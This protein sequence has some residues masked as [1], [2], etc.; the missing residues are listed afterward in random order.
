M[1]YRCANPAFLYK[2]SHIIVINKKLLNFEQT[3][4]EDRNKGRSERISD[5]STRVAKNTLMLYF[6]MLL[7]MFIGL[8]TSRIILKTLGV[9]DYDVYGT[10]GSIVAAFTV[11]T[12]AISQAISRFI[13]FE[14]GNGDK[15]KLSRIFS[16]SVII[17]I[18]FTIVIVILTE[19]LG[20]WYLDHRIILPEGR[21]SAAHWVLQCS[22]GILIVNLLSVP[23]NAVI[24]AHEKM[25]AYAYISI[26]EA[27]LKLTVALL[28]FVS[29][30]DKLISFSILML[31]TALIVRFT[32]GAYCKKH[33]EETCGSLK[34]DSGLLK[35][36]SGF[37]GWNFLGSGSYI[38]NTQGINLLAN[39]FFGVGVNAARN[40][41]FQVENIIK[42]FVTNFLTALNPQIIKSFAN[43]ESAYCF[44]LT[45]KGVKFS[46]LVM[47]AFLAPLLFEAPFLLHIWLRNVP[48]MSEVF[49]RL[50]VL[51]LMSDMSFNPLL[52][53]IQA[54]GKIK[55][56]YISSSLVSILVFFI[57]WTAF[58]TGCPAY[59]SYIVFAVVYFI[60]D[61]IKLATVYHQV[62]FPVTTLIK[63]ELL[64]LAAVTALTLIFSFICWHL[65]PAG[66][67][68]LLAVVTVS[69]IVIGLSSWM[70]V[71]TDGEK[72]FIK[73][74]I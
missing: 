25:K 37:A 46:Y 51:C 39:A 21:E 69:T 41:A 72:N 64:P 26:L 57:S 7:M 24:T 70:F 47:L 15:E 62:K 2:Y 55:G 63:K 49:V 56:Y 44:E 71:L 33:F 4:S 42:Q 38:V 16:T 66:A 60:V 58:K 61:G 45:R 9:S 52:T 6:R 73:S 35:E 19:T 12:T 74:K 10:V 65:I 68:R 8:F 34:F 48:P 59:V 31:C 53:L 30:A 3:M 27:L 22:M 23:F 1:H 67:I 20:L 29:P 17:Q 11:V 54:N 18:L 40:V 32:Y 13:T 14:L 36:M 50:T 28:L 5:N 43:G